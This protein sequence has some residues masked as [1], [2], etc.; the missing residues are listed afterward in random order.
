M[1]N[2]DISVDSLRLS[3]D[4]AEE[5]LEMDA[6]NVSVLSSSFAWPSRTSDALSSIHN[7]Q[8]SKVDERRSPQAVVLNGISLPVVQIAQQE[9]QQ[10]PFQLASG[11]TSFAIENANLSV[12]FTPQP[13]TVLQK[14][15][16]QT[17]TL[18]IMNNLP[19]LNPNSPASLIGASPGKS[20]SI[21]K[22]I[23]AHCGRDCLKPSVLE[24]HIRSHT[25][26]R[27]FPCNI[28]G[29]SFKTQSNLYKHRRTQTHVNNAKQSFDSDCGS[30][31]DDKLH[32]VHNTCLDLSSGTRDACMDNSHFIQNKNLSGVLE[33]DCLEGS[34]GDACILSPAKIHDKSHGDSDYLSQTIFS[35]GMPNLQRTVIDPK[36]TGSSRHG[37]LQRQHETCVDKQWDSSPSERKLKKCESTDS[38][39]LSHSDSADLQMFSGSPLHS[40]S[41]CSI[42]SE[43]M[44]GIG[45]GYVEDKTASSHKKNLEERISMLISQNKAVVDNTHLDN[46]RP[47][48]TALSKQG[49]IDLPMPY[50]FKDS[51]HFDIKSLDANRK[52]LSSCSAK[53]TFTPSEKNKPLF[54]HSV[55]TQISTTIENIILTRSNSLPFVESGRLKDRLNVHNILSHGSGKQPLNVSHGNLL[56]SNTATACTVDF[57]SSHPR[58]LVRQAA[59]DEMQICNGSDPTICEEIK[60][61]NKATGDQFSSKSK[62]ANKKGGQRKL[63]MFS[64]EKWQIYGDETFKKF[65]Q[66]MKKSDLVKKTKQD[67][68]E[69]KGIIGNE[70]S[71]Q[72]ACELGKPSKKLS[73]VPV[74]APPTSSL[75]FTCSYAITSASKEI[76]T[77]L[78]IG[79]GHITLD[80]ES[81]VQGKVS[82]AKFSS[83]INMSKGDMKVEQTV[84]KNVPT[85]S[86]GVCDNS[87]IVVME[88]QLKG[89]DHLEADNFK[90][91]EGSPS[92]R[93]KIKVAGLKGEILYSVSL[94]I[95]EDTIDLKNKNM[96]CITDSGNTMRTLSGSGTSTV[97]SCHSLSTIIN[98]NIFL[99]QEDSGQIPAHS[100]KGQHVILT[101]ESS[102]TL[103]GML[104]SPRYLI[105]FNYAETS[106]DKSVLQSNQPTVC[107]SF[108][109]DLINITEDTNSNSLHAPTKGCHQTLL[110]NQPKLTQDSV[111]APVG[112]INLIEECVPICCSS[113]ISQNLVQN[114]SLDTQGSQYQKVRLNDTYLDRH[115]TFEDHKAVKGLISKHI[116]LKSLLSTDT[117]STSEVKKLPHDP[118]LLDII[119]PG[120]NIWKPLN[121]TGFLNQENSSF[122]TTCTS[123]SSG[124]YSIK[125]TQVTFSTMNT[126]PK[127]TWC[128]LNRC[129]PLPAEQKEKSCSVYASL[130][131]DDF[132]ERK[133]EPHGNRIEKDMSHMTT[134]D[135][136]PMMSLKQKNCFKEE[137]DKGIYHPLVKK[138]SK[139]GTIM[140]SRH[141]KRSKD[142]TRGHSHSKMSQHKTTGALGQDQQHTQISC[143][144]NLETGEILLRTAN[145]E[146]SDKEG[147]KARIH[148]PTFHP[149]GDLNQKNEDK[150]TPDSQMNEGSITTTVQEDNQ[151][152]QPME[153]TTDLRPP[154]LASLSWQKSCLNALP[155]DNEVELHQHL[156]ICPPRNNVRKI[157]HRSKT[158]G[159]S[160]GDDA[161]GSTSRM[162]SSESQPRL[163]VEAKD[164]IGTSSL[165]NTSSLGFHM[166]PNTHSSGSSLE[167]GTLSLNH[168]EPSGPLCQ[169]HK[170]QK[171]INL[172]L[173]RKQTHVEYSDSSSDDE[174][175]LYIE[176]LE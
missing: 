171:K 120:G 138:S 102:S 16:S 9:G 155:T 36:S 24:K 128:W 20:K 42:E 159:H 131:S 81:N 174:D 40:L 172:E 173:M 48:K 124:I 127:S 44:L 51:F 55:P 5:P 28:C 66:K 160:L 91:H 76:D 29:I 145:F 143:P 121:R 112:K 125:V 149:G 8:S 59:V 93:K 92:D 136:Q 70:I 154:R 176:I 56:L 175:R 60:E 80:I 153:K 54:F 12:I 150:A 117:M 45:S 35:P 147:S 164:G 161:V 1:C 94:D 79:N 89:H 63:N 73:S 64:H 23:C 52:K 113:K 95:P 144:S 104:F 53:S 142:G 22:H 31:H 71:L 50:T 132:K 135:G 67:T 118:L 49:S 3:R 84:P 25:G 170:T 157:L 158:I 163:P 34:K 19:I 65:Y 114:K 69:S 109:S 68:S 15:P 111:I 39:Y 41:E 115:N 30:Y 133:L 4:T 165:Q 130:S 126:E 146:L 99:S 43:N 87:N 27:P 137:T 85:P 61:K 14:P 140:K 86:T 152:L 33:N 7:N 119:Q 88:N 105:E 77:P 123:S 139:M 18:N 107:G 156:S 98:K 17:I 83:G 72:P 148:H 58:G 82:E 38:G 74:V 141:V 97:V 106:V 10:A 166:V 103:K 57:S 101:T 26:E 116:D 151:S 110:E 21:G 96:D 13:Q 108:S 162:T 167:P 90:I 134:I 32:V 46:V 6:S 122:S 100:K 129:L 2:K 11:G 37:Q 168:G 169:S 62:I 75:Q 78:S 47:R